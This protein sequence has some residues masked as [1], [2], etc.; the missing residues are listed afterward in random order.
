M[1][2]SAGLPAFFSQNPQIAKPSNRRHYQLMRN[3][4]LLTLLAITMATG[5]LN[6]TAQAAPVYDKPLQVISIHS[7][8]LS[9]A[10]PPAVSCTYYAD[11]MV[12]EDGV[13]GPSEG[14]AFILP[15]SPAQSI[16]RCNNVTP[17]QHSIALRSQGFSID[18]RKGNFLIFVFDDPTGAGQF[19]IFNIQTGKRLFT[20]GW[21]TTET[22]TVKDGAL[23][24]L[25]NR[26]INAPCSLIT[27]HAACW[28]QII[29]TGQ[30]PRGAFAGP[31]SVKTCEESYQAEAVFEKRPIPYDDESIISYDTDLTLDSEGHAA[32]PLQCY[33]EP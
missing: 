18:G 26:G 10:R 3:K 15:V 14:S 25:Y 6:L 17:P 33:P 7:P 9:A 27:N 28:T 32:G 23:H 8:Q 5:L 22:V 21:N 11:A 20:D 16:P 4:L 29:E 12:L 31:P 13:D 1:P 2:P 30:I 24:V 19:A